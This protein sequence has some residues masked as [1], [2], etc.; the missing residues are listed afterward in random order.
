MLVTKRKIY[1]RSKC[2]D[3]SHDKYYSCSLYD[4]KEQCS[5]CLIVSL[6]KFKVTLFESNR[7]EIP[8]CWAACPNCGYIYSDM[9]ATGLV[10]KISDWSKTPLIDDTTKVHCASCEN[11]EALKWGFSSKDYSRFYARFDWAMI[12][13]AKECVVCLE[14]GLLSVSISLDQLLKNSGN[15]VS[16]SWQQT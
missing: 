5:P 8:D 15:A 6:S 4:G 3:C 9:D 7:I 2:P 14:C 1:R 16:K 11:G 13:I 10:R 12:E